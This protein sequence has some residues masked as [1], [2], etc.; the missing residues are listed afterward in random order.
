MSSSG[1]AQAINEELVRRLTNAIVDRLFDES[2]EELLKD[3]HGEFIDKTIGALKPQLGASTS[4]REHFK[5]RN[6]RNFVKGVTFMDDFCEV[7][8]RISPM[9]AN[10]SPAI[11]RVFVD[12]GSGDGECLLAAAAWS[13]SA[14]ATDAATDA[15]QHIV[16]YELNHAR[17]LESRVLAAVLQYLHPHLPPLQTVEEDFLQCDGWLPTELAA[18]TGPVDV[19]VYACA[20]CYTAD[21]V[22]GILSR[23]GQLSREKDGQYRVRLVLLDQNLDALAPP[24]AGTVTSA[25]DLL[26]AA[27]WRLVDDV[28]HIRTSWGE[29]HARIYAVAPR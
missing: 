29:G 9:D 11:A 2:H 20:T 22:E 19:V 13:A 5:R 18:A 21:V 17:V 10:Q 12:L 1:C 7:F 14:T 23:C 3:A 6:P 16:G 8:R 15:F 4:I 26:T 24:V 25:N 28:P 27:T